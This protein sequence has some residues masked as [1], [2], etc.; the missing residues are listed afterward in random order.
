MGAAH[1]EPTLSATTSDDGHELRPRFVA[2]LDGSEGRR[3][4]ELGGKAFNLNR[5]VSMGAR[6]PR[7]FAVKTGAYRAITEQPSLHS[8]IKSFI[9]RPKPL[10]LQELQSETEKLRRIFLAHPVPENIL[11]EIKASY[12]RLTEE[13]PGAEVSVRSSA[14]S[15]D[16]AEA[17]FAGLHSTFLNV[18][19][20]EEVLSSV[21]GCWAS[22]WSPGAVS[23]RERC[24]FDHQGV[25]MGVVVQLM[26]PA[27]RS[28]VMFTSNPVNASKDEVVINA[29][30]GLGEKLVSGQVTPDVYVVDRKSRTTLKRNV[31][32]S[33]DTPPDPPSKGQR[34]QASEDAASGSLTDRQIRGLVEAGLHIE[35]GFGEPQDIEWAIMGD[36]IHVL[37]SRPIFTLLSRHD[38]WLQRSPAQI[39]IEKPVIE[40]KRSDKKQRK[41]AGTKTDAEARYRASRQLRQEWSSRIL[42]ALLEEID[43]FKETD[44][45]S[46]PDADLASS[47]ED[48]VSA[49]KEHF[50][51]RIRVG[52]LIDA[53]VERLEPY[54]S[55]VGFIS[56]EETPM[57]LVGF[58][59]KDSESD[60]ALKSLASQASPGI[61]DVLRKGPEAL[62]ELEGV[63]G[64]ADW[65]RGFASYLE[66]F[67][68]L[69]SAKWDVMAPTYGESPGFLLSTIVSHA[70]RETGQ[71]SCPSVEDEREGLVRRV[72][73]ALPEEDKSGFKDALGV[74]QSNYPLKDDRDFYYLMSLAQVRRTLLEAG[75][76]LQER[77][78]IESVEDVFF[79][80][81]DEV[82][83]LIVQPGGTEGLRAKIKARR[84]LFNERAQT[85]NEWALESS[86]LD[87]LT[88]EGGATVLSGMGISPGVSTGRARVV[89]S[90]HEFPR[91][92]AGDIL[93]SPAVSPAWAPILGV[94]RG[95]V[96]DVGGSLSHGGILARE[97]GIPAV[98]STGIGTSV[99]KEGQTITVDGGS[100]RVY[101]HRLEEEAGEAC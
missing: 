59:N 34:A 86:K 60:K 55:R 15:E 66:G 82:P 63:E 62:H 90:F 79:V 8:A 77:G 46:L 12:S 13:A 53:S 101:L 19:G 68:H 67:G 20:L 42:P 94:A 11:E 43:S 35:D 91:L 76:R 32:L 99:I 21:K 97:Y 37:Q 83:L 65:A 6:V 29:V 69:S 58:A 84:L 47:L 96:T 27:D 4:S 25:A 75:R 56:P 85:R 39:S 71:R 89:R 30:R 81:T 1:V 61:M 40:Q 49:N 80:G 72:V 100:G 17:S 9:D 28:G 38:I 52:G 44:F 51:L 22:L 54:L 87:H 95:I 64:G 92:E 50:R 88:S 98:V 48:V 5:L 70:S 57:L 14:T 33:G 24:G 23:Y 2:E 31:A 7:C 36:E 26:V 10:T 78:V 41:E 74:A 93:V 3:V 18:S 73:D 45:A 16:L